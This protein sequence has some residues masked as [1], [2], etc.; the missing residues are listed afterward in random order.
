MSALYV[1]ENIYIFLLL[2]V[3]VYKNANE[4]LQTKKNQQ[5]CL[6]DLILVHNFINHYYYF[7]F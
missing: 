1:F 7:S 4:I 3:F 6:N 2:L 5:V